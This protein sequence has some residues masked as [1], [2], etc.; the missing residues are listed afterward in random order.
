[1]NI[2]KKTRSDERFCKLRERVKSEWER[3]EV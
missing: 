3:F 2:I 1:M